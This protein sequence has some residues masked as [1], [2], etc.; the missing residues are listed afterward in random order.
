[1]R[2]LAKY[3]VTKQELINFLIREQNKI[4]PED[5]APGDL[6]P[7]YLDLLKAFVVKNMPDDYRWPILPPRPPAKQNPG[8]PDA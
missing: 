3:P 2:N 5:V 7:T 4:A 8:L 1:M 6:E